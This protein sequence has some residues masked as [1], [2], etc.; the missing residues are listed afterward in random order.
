MVFVTKLLVPFSITN[1]E[2]SSLSLSDFNDVFECKAHLR[3]Y[4]VLSNILVIVARSAL[5]IA[6]IN[7]QENRTCRAIIVKH[8]WYG[9][10]Y[11]A[12]LS[13]PFLKAYFNRAFVCFLII[14]FYFQ[15]DW[16]KN[17]KFHYLLF[18][19][20]HRHNKSDRK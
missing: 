12:A 5:T 14:L 15:I 13:I 19:I 4:R 8:G 11:E 2:F 1:F 20:F 6:I 7:D 18:L 9:V 17:R 16:T 10:K 3:P